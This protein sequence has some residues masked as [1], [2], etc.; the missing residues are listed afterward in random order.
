MTT[1]G[2]PSCLLGGRTTKRAIVVDVVSCAQPFAFLVKEAGRATDLL[3]NGDP[4]TV[5]A[6]VSVLSPK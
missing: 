3:A 5:P 4:E 1:L 6:T 2:G